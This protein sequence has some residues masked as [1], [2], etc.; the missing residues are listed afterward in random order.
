MRPSIRQPAVARHSGA[1]LRSAT[2]PRRL[3]PAPRRPAP[4]G[5]F[6]V[7]R[8]PPAFFRRPSG[9]WATAAIDAPALGEHAPSRST[10]VRLPPTAS[11]LHGP[12][13]RSPRLTPARGGPFPVG[14]P[15]PR[16][17]RAA[18]VSRASRGRAGRGPPLRR[19]VA[20]GRGAGPPGGVPSASC[21]TGSARHPRSDRCRPARSRSP[22]CRC[23]SC[24]S[25]S[26]NETITPSTGRFPRRI[27]VLSPRTWGCT[28]LVGIAGDVDGIVPTH[29]GVYRDGEDRTLSTDRCPHARGGV[30]GANEMAEVI[31]TSSP[32]A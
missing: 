18:A 29:V 11:G 25:R 22:P 28:A 5:R 27:I 6:P 24:P 26:R 17:P 13:R 14:E 9:H 21:H 3:V 31:G 8:E 10:D 4:T 16:Q 2:A 12:G 32:R 30:P 7:P 15:S 19:R 20:D 23:P 1:L